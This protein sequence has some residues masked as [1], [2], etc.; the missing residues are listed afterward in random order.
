MSNYI[1]R[2]ELLAA[3]LKD[4]EFRARYEQHVGP[5]SALLA[6]MRAEAGLTQQQVATR[7]GVGRPLVSMLESGTITNSRW[8]TMAAIAKACGYR[9]VLT[10]EKVE[11]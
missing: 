2:V 10:I 11:P 3:A 8:R 5:F 9:L 7:A 1:P 6:E 4:P